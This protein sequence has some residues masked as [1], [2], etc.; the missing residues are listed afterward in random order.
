[1][2]KESY[3][4]AGCM[5][6]V[7]IMIFFIMFGFFN[8]FPSK[9]MNV[10]GKIL[11]KNMGTTYFLANYNS[12]F[13]YY[14]YIQTDDNIQMVSVKKEDYFSLNIGDVKSFKCTVN[15]FSEVYDK[16]CLIFNR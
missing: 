1:M 8:I 3:S 9:N 12:P 10:S 15:G 16:P 13:R 14:L 4:S 6:F 7:G 11:D 2:K 5:L